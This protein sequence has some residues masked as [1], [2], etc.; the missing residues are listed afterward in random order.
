MSYRLA[1]LPAG[2]AIWAQLRWGMRRAGFFF[3]LPEL[4]ALMRF[5]SRRAVF[6]SRFWADA[7]QAV[8]AHFSAEDNGY[9]RMDRDGLT[10]LARGGEVALDSHLML[11]MMGDKALSYGLL[12][13]MG[14]AAVPHLVVTPGEWR[15]AEAF[16][17]G[18]G[19]PVVVK[20]ASG[21]GG[22]RGVT[23][24]VSSA[25]SLSR[26]MRYAARYDRRLIIEP[27]LE[28]QSHRLLFVGGR[29]V[30]AVRRDAPFIVGDGTHSIARL[31]RME[32][33][34][35]LEGHE[36]LSLN[37]ILR[38]PDFLNT[39]KAQGLSARYV[40]QIGEIVRIKTAINENNRYGNE[41]VSARVHPQTIA[42][43]RR[44][45]G[46]L[47]V[48]LA[49]VDVHCADIS[50]P[51]DAQRGYITEI[52]TTPGLHHHCLTREGD[53]REGGVGALLLDYM[54]ATGH[55]AMRL[56][57]HQAVHSSD[58]AVLAEAVRAEAVLAEAQAEE[59]FA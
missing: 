57:V 38:N 49:G 16:A 15:R 53:S 30:D 20:P 19:W 11:E 12:A 37:P 10:V 54:F 56:A 14:S 7:A 25:N 1:T 58:E 29:F 48:Q 18:M 47:G 8:G 52:N 39:L 32:N 41:R 33:R 46:A 9:F 42:E 55:G 21:T 45:V 5:R 50:K 59:E 28:G 6:W 13:Q 35:R 24:R 31:V 26:A 27:Q 36:F 2:G 23:T 17:S 3:N 4:S 34:K 22:G 44:I 51:L 43:C 40:P